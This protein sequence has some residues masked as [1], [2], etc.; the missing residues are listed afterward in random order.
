MNIKFVN[1]G[2]QAN[3]DSIMLFQTAD[4][5]PYWSDALFHFFPALDRD[6]FRALGA[7]ARKE[8]LS[9]QLKAIYQEQEALINQKAEAYNS[10]WQTHRKQV[11]EAFSEAFELES[12][13]L[14]NDLRAEVTLNPVSPRFLLERHFQVFYLNSE[15]GALG[16]SIH[17]MVHY[18]WFHVWNQVF[19]DD[20]SE[21]ERPSL[22]WILSEMVVESIMRDPRLSSL[23]PYFPRENGGCV[24]R[25]FQDMVLEGEMALDV[26]EGL[27]QA[28]DIRTF[29]RESF[30]YCKQHEDAIRAHIQEAEQSF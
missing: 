22:K 24:Y 26:I 16:I 7:D 20:Y 2:F 27:Y 13:A 8:Y 9:L 14:F 30:A 10:H 3:I 4:E 23:D 18:L 1:P 25:Y 19:Q 5:T 6:R 17:E 15:R 21:Y 28:G 11:E 12:S 29:M